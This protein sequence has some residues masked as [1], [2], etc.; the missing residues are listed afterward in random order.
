MTQTLTS[1]HHS[2]LWSVRLICQAELLLVHKKRRLQSDL[3]SKRVSQTAVHN[4]HADKSMKSMIGKQER[5]A[6]P[7]INL[8]KEGKKCASAVTE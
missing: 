7:R 3:I 6:R 4:A 5:K 8:E 2:E 1:W